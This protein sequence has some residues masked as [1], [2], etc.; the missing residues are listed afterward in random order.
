[1]KTRIKDNGDSSLAC[2]SGFAPLAACLFVEA[3]KHK[4]QALCFRWSFI[5]GVWRPI[6]REVGRPSWDQKKEHHREV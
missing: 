2:L 5:V 3:M 4:R 6:E 1:M